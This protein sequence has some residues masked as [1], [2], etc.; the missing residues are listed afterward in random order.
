MHK[1]IS[2][3]NAPS[4]IGAYAQAILAN[5]ILY[6]SGQIPVNPK[7]GEIVIGIEEETHQVMRNIEAILNESGMTFSNVVKSS[8]FLRDMEQFP[9][10]NAIYASYFH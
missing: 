7:T 3:K 10:V 4:A 5:G 1:A 8:I 6:I 2:S 9:I